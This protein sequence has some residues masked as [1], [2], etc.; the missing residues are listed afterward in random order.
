[1]HLLQQ[2]ILGIIILLLL[3][4]LVIVKK[5]A[6]G[7]VLDKPGGNPLVQL[8]NIYNLFFLLIVNPLTAI[9]LIARRFYALDPTHLTITEPL[10]VLAVE[11]LGLVMYVTGYL[12]MAWALVTLGRNYQLGGSAPRSEDRMI[13]DGPYRL[14][15]H[16]MYT[17]ALSISLGLALLTQSWAFLCVFSVYLA[18]I[19]L[20]I[21][22]EEERLLKAYGGQYVS[23]RQ[24]TGKLMFFDR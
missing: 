15:R 18:L 20:L 1:M 3:G 5:S 16:P 6:T 12:L 7:A 10:T 21:P 19:L 14:A 11:L 8:V 24:K 2:W 17:A 13:T 9:A 4:I 23:Y 22:V